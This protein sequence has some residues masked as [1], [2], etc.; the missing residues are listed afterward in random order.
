MPL[1]I[2]VAVGSVAGLIAGSFAAKEVFQNKQKDIDEI[3]EK[4]SKLPARFGPFEGFL[5]AISFTSGYAYPTSSYSFSDNDIINSGDFNNIID[6]LGTRTSTNTLAVSY[7]LRNASSIDPG[8]LHSTASTTFR[9]TNVSS[10][11]VSSTNATF[12][13]PI[14]VNSGGTNAS[15]GALSYGVVIA[16][17]TNA[18]STVAPSTLDNVLTSNG[19]AWVSSAVT[20][21]AQLYSSSTDRTVALAG[22]TETFLATSTTIG[23]MNAT[24]M[25]LVAISG[26][27]ASD[28]AGTGP[29]MKI[30]CGNQVV[31]RV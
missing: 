21:K 13:N 24:D 17:S 23:A 11:N 9:A 19:S 22:A 29:F 16:S 10:T 3:V 28:Y 31:V 14:S 30:R 7:L 25:L 8:H 1:L 27:A 15:S 2:A 26:D 12:T 5:G 20:I 6:Y 18:F 4:Q